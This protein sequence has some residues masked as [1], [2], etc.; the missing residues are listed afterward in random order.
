MS[1]GLAGAT[2]VVGTWRVP[3]RPVQKNVRFDSEILSLEFG[4]FILSCLHVDRDTASLDCNV[5]IVVMSPSRGLHVGSVIMFL[6]SVLGSSLLLRRAKVRKYQYHQSNSLSTTGRPRAWT[7][8][9]THSGTPSKEDSDYNDTLHE[10]FGAVKNTAERGHKHKPVGSTDLFIARKVYFQAVATKSGMDK[11][12]VIHIAGSKGKGSVVEYISAALRKS[13]ANVGIF[14]SPHLHTARE[15]IKVKSEL[16]SKEDLTRIGKQN[17]KELQGKN[18]PVFFDYLLASA[19][20]YF[21]EK[22]VDYVVLETGIGGRFDST[23]FVDNPSI[24]VITSIS[25]DHTAILGATLEL[26]AWQKAGII[27]RGMHIFTPATQEPE[28]LEV[29]KK[30]CSDVDATLHVVPVDPSEVSA[31]LQAPDGTEETPTF[32]V[33]VQNACLAKQVVEKLGLDPSHMQAAYWPCRMESFRVN[34]PALYA[35]SDAP[36][37]DATVVLDGA[38]NGDSVNLFLKGLREAYPNR[39]I[40][41]LFGAGMEKALNDMLQAV[42]MHA[43]SVVFVQSR[44]FKAASE[45]ELHAAAIKEGYTLRYPP[46]SNPLSRTGDGTVARRL[47]DAILNGGSNAAPL[48]KDDPLRGPGPVIAICGS[49]FAAA[50]AREALFG[51]EPTLFKANDWV[52]KMDV[53]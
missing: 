37:G 52:R 3:T 10:L 24:G 40:R 13:N 33:Q 7:T 21:G 2:R 15:R 4:I 17:I 48:S 14:T 32:N 43:D 28:V 11:A 18:W 42:E 8:T 27:K 12:N 53:L 29:I 25:Y 30:Q 20:Q 9:L 36:P 49:L 34:R 5:C 39:H 51:L 38:H 44:H 47:K 46:H 31:I 6:S 1:N 22:K 19:I 45:Q 35:G 16:I 41:V 26:I 23:N 50:E